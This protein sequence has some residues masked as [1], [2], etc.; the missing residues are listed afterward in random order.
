M[1]ASSPGVSHPYGLRYR[2]LPL[3]A[4]AKTNRL[5]AVTIARWVFFGTELRRAVWPLTQDGL[6][7]CA[8]ERD[9]SFK[10]EFVAEAYRNQVLTG[11]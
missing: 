7:L 1:T 2:L 10:A 9:S 8:R 11:S 5:S 6:T 4:C 3:H